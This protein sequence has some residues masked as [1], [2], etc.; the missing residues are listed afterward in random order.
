[1]DRQYN[2]LPWLCCEV[3]KKNNSLVSSM[4]CKV[5]QEFE[6]RIISNFSSVWIN[7]LIDIVED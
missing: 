3:G 6:D 2:T 7:G 5:Y 1:M 4:H